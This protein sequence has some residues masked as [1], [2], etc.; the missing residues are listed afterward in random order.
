MAVAVAAAQIRDQLIRGVQPDNSGRGSSQTPCLNCLLC[1]PSPF[2]PGH[3]THSMTHRLRHK[4]RQSPPLH[5]LPAPSRAAGTP[6]R[7][8]SDA[9]LHAGL[10]WAV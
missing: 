1:Y 10:I 5:H 9:T 7:Q 2:A 6:G 8:A 4:A 3:S